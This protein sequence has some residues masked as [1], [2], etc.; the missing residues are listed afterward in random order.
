MGCRPSHPFG[1]QGRF[2]E[3]E[4]Q[5]AKPKITPSSLQRYRVSQKQYRGKRPS[6]HRGRP[7]VLDAVQQ[8][9]KC[10]MFIEAVKR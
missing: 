3:L 1:L 5:L 10:Y 8:K 2:L 9:R 6:K 7:S 4:A